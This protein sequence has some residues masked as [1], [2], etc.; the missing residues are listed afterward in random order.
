VVN[1]FLGIFLGI[2]TTEKE[3]GIAFVQSGKI[4]HEILVETEAQHNE[5]IFT[6]LDNAFKTLSLFPNQLN[7]IGVVLGP[8]MFTSIRVGLACAKGLAVVNNIPIKGFNTLDALVFSL[9]DSILQDTRTIMP[10]LD[11]HRNEIYFR[12]YQGLEPMSES[13]L[14]K[15]EIFAQKITKDA[16]VFGSGISHYLD[17]IQNQTKTNFTVYNLTI[18]KPSAVAFHASDCISKQDFSDIETLVPI[19]VR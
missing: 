5:T 17:I 13:L 12:S 6:F 11:V 16:V 15:P 14:A 1:N 19:Y 4:L 10:A 8:G 18:P 2:S 9:P 7:G 3:T